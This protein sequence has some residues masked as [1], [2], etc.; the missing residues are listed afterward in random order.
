VA[1]NDFTITWN[2]SG[3]FTINELTFGS[4]H[5][6]CQGSNEWHRLLDEL[7]GSAE[8]F[9]DQFRRSSVHPTAEA[10]IER[11]I[12]MIVQNDFSVPSRVV[13][14]HRHGNDGYLAVALES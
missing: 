12:E 7:G 2:S 5:V 9:T 3:V 10:A 11:L 13:V 8:A 6:F 4:E 1:V 14:I